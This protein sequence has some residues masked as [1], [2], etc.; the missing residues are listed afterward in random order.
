M[1][2]KMKRQNPRRRS[3]RKSLHPSHHRWG[4][5]PH[6]PAQLRTHARHEHETKL[7]PISQLGLAG[8]SFP[9]ISNIRVY[10]IVMSV[11]VMASSLETASSHSVSVALQ[12]IQCRGQL[13]FGVIASHTHPQLKRM[14]F[15]RQGRE[16]LCI[17][18]GSHS[19]GSD[20]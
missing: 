4:H 1:A 10:Y 2:P 5:L 11:P 8:A 14:G 13:V 19:D 12:M 9:P 6:A 18:E 16:K 3:R 15:R 7:K 17:F 20:L